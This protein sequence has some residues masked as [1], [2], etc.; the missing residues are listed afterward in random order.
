[1][2]RIWMA[3]VIA[4]AVAAGCSEA[5][6]TAATPGGGGGGGGAAT[7]APGG[8]G[9]G[10]GNATATIKINGTSTTIKG[11]T[12]TDIGALGTEVAVG[13]FTAGQAG[14][15]DFFDMFVK[16]NAVTTVQGRAGGVYFVLAAGKESGSI[17]ADMTGSFS[18]TDTI[19]GNQVEGT[20]ACNG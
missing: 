5:A 6:S 17:G 1:M 16:G 12:C 9:G 20:F 8:G 3:M 4:V 15:G 14:K 2:R 11:G 10:G 19:T 13:D 18:G 7:K